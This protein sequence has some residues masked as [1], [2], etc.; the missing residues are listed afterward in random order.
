MRNLKSQANTSSIR[1]EVEG[2][3]LELKKVQDDLVKVKQEVGNTVTRAEIDQVLQKEVSG[4]I[5]KFSDKIDDSVKEIR[6]EIK[7]EIE[8]IKTTSFVDIMKE[9]MEKSLGNMATEIESVKTNIIEQKATAEEQRDKESRRNNVILY[10]VTESTAAKAEERNK[11]DVAFCLR[12]F[13][14]GLH[15]GITEEELPRKIFF[16]SSV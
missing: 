13:N 5:S 7:E 15:V 1:K 3:R 12:L 9:E 11:D 2:Q 10:K 14:N 6:V 8:E 16:M 4:K